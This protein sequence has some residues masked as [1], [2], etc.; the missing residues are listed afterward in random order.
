MAFQLADVGFDEA[1]CMHVINT[2]LRTDTFNSDSGTTYLGDDVF[3]IYD[4]PLCEDWLQK[5]CK[6]PNQ[7]VRLGD[8]TFHLVM[9]LDAKA[10]T[11][12]KLRWGQPIKERVQSA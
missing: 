8:G 5:D 10:S 4:Y 9:F 2:I 11:E 6:W 3:L 1:G 12:F 7:V